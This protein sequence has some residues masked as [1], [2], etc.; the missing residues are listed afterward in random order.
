MVRAHADGLQF[1]AGRVTAAYFYTEDAVIPLHAVTFSSTI[2][3]V[4][5]AIYETR[6][7]S[8]WSYAF[9]RDPE[10]AVR[11]VDCRQTPEDGICRKR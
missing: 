2:D 10:G 6:G 3:G 11:F 4:N 7:Y 1:T 5:R 8:P 9:K